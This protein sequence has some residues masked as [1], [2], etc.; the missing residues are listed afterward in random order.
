MPRAKIALVDRF[1]ET[2]GFGFGSFS[3]SKK[4]A[5]I[6]HI[7][8]HP[9]EEDRAFAAFGTLVSITYLR[10]TILRQLAVASASCPCK[11]CV[12]VVA[13]V[14]ALDHREEQRKARIRQH[15]RYDLEQAHNDFVDGF[16]Q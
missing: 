15:A 14:A 11:R 10:Q 9:F 6:A 7:E 16:T 2:P 5:K 1:R 8:P 3:L 4:S 12:N 13:M